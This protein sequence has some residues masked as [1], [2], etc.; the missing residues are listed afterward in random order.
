MSK[1]GGAAM[2]ATGLIRGIARVDSEGKI[3]I[4]K[5]ILTAAELRE[6]DIVELRLTRSGKTRKLTISKCSSSRKT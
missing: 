5:N 4:P 1:E 6:R 3:L 2:S